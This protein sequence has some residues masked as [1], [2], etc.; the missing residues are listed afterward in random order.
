MST[1]QWL[2]DVA[3]STSTTVG[4]SGEASVVKDLIGGGI[5]AA[6]VAGAVAGFVRSSRRF[7]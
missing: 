5:L 2:A 1:T 7:R 6:I 4:V 3:A